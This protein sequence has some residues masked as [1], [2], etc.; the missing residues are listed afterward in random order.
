MTVFVAVEHGK[1][2]IRLCRYLSKQLRMEIVPV[3]RNNGEETIS[4]RESGEFLKQG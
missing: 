2:E 4:L 1:C 3:S